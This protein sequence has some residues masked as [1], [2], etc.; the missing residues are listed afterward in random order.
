MNYFRGKVIKP[1][2]KR[3]AG[4]KIFK[5]FRGFL[6][7]MLFKGAFVFAL[8]WLLTV[9]C[10]VGFC[11]VFAADDPIIYPSVDRLIETYLVPVCCL[12]FSII[13]LER[14]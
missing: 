7:K 3:I 10:F 6:N 1:L 12:L 4:G 2:V 9:L 11:F 8:I 13:R 5:L 14:F